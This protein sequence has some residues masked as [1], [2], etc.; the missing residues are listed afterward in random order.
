MKYPSC[1]RKYTEKLFPTAKR[2][3]LITLET[4]FKKM[5]L[6]QA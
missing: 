6:Q 1:K 4:Q 3:R 5:A 2:N